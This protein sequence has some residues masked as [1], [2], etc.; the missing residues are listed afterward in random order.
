MQSIGRGAAPFLM[1][2]GVK[3]V[4]AI[5]NPHVAGAQVMAKARAIEA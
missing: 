2:E 3:P 1:T 5:P 4:G